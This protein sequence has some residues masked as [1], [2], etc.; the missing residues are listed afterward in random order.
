MNISLPPI[1]SSPARDCALTRTI[2][3]AGVLLAFGSAAAWAQG[4][5]PLHNF[6]GGT[7][8]GNSIS[9]P[10]VQASDGTI[11]GVTSGGGASNNGT[12][13]KVQPDGSGYQVVFSFPA[14]TNVAR[15]PF[16]S[17]IQGRDGMLY[18]TGFVGGASNGGAL[19]KISP[20][21]TGFTVI[22]SFGPNEG[23]APRGGLVQGADGIL[24]GA[25]SAGSASSTV[26]AD[27]SG[28]IWR[29]ATDGSGYRVLFSFNGSPNYPNGI[30][31]N[32][33]I[34][35]RD[36]A[37]Y[38]MTRGGG[39]NG[40]P[41]SSP[42]AIF[43]IKTDGTG[44]AVL[45]SF[46]N[47]TN[48]LPPFNGGDPQSPLVHAPDG[49]L[50]GAT[51]GGGR[52]LNGCVFK[53]RPDG[54]GFEV[55]HSFL[56]TAPE[57][58]FEPQDAFFLGRDGSLYGRTRRGGTANSGVIFKI[59]TDGT[60]FRVI[61]ND[62]GAVAHYA[63]LQG[64]DG[65]LYAHSATGATPAVSQLVR[66]V[67]PPGLVFTQQPLSQ[68]VAPGGNVTF[69]VAAPGATAF[70]WRRDGTNLAGAT[71]ATL[72]L[73][74]VTTSNAGTYTV[75]ASN[76][77][78]SATS[79]GAVL[80]VG[81]AS[82]VA[83]LT[84]L[85]ILTSL[86]GSADSFT[87]GYVVGGA[88]TAGAKPLVIRA[89]GPSLAQL[90]VGG[91]LPDPRLELFAGAAASGAN[92]NWGGAAA[93]LTAMNNVGAFPFAS[94][95]SLDAAVATSV[96]AGDNSVKVS[97]VGNL[98]GAV[99]AEIYDAT[100]AA[101]FTTATPRLVNVSVLKNIGTSL[102]AGFVIGGT[103]SRTVLIRAVGPT[104]GAAP[105][106]V[107]GVV[108]DPQLVLFSGQTQIGAN[109]NWGG[110]AALTAAFTQVGAFALPAASRDAA[111]LVTLQPGNYSVQVSGVGATTG[112]AI[113][114]VYEVP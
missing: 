18:G 102:T 106:N 88:G 19:Y 21:G 113:V 51:R 64:A 54:T 46:S 23:V 109:D 114:E 99:I 52:T 7:T 87:M 34:Q 111:L 16:Y 104:L 5:T 48:G 60:G 47:A 86:S 107:P 68:T 13:F 28:T 22:H 69:T 95:T 91:P 27:G 44:F 43:T 103:G 73:T 55:I 59:R 80:A 96:T 74:N 110:T 2:A 42:G 32:S 1:G 76:A 81:T 105:F 85:S 71:A 75:V 83:R 108:A 38:G 89:A 41:T 70:Q 26:G 92:D 24:Y 65:A 57:N 66:V 12:I 56:R 93:L 4:S 53:L 82:A 9:A 90:G 45:Q 14:G 49:F 101:A 98:S 77:T 3:L 79:A 58:G 11:Y 33:L 15:V 6:A 62:P 17:F 72:T 35:G 30:E 50:Y 67:E 36:G 40:T 100:P 112:V 94:A 10:L 63:L 25:T 78:D 29:C 31:P 39:A 20:D 61:A 84:N 8:D 37:L 97:P